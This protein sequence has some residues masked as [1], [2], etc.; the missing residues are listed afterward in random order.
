V[1]NTEN[2]VKNVIATLVSDVALLLTMRIGLVRLRIHRNMFGLGQLLWNQGLVWL[3]LATIAEV[4]PAV[5]ISLNLNSSLNLMF[6]TPGLVVMSI[7][8]TQMHRSLTDFADS[9]RTCS[10]F[11]SY[12]TRC[13]D[14]ASTDPKRIFPTSVPL[15]RVEVS[16]HTSS[17]SKDYTPENMGQYAPYGSSRAND[18]SQD[19]PL[20]LIVGSNLENG[21]ERMRPPGA[22]TICSAL[23]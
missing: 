21:V 4:P 13:G 14:M 16:V 6:Q 11:D 5:F 8:A 19:N 15:N 7:G 3:F 17:N 9:G 12:P 1:L 18:Q 22:R 20:V 10:S 23:H 2:G